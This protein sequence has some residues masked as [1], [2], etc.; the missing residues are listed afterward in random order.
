MEVFPHAISNAMENTAIRQNTISFFASSR[1][2]VSRPSIPENRPSSIFP[3]ALMSN[4]KIPNS[5]SG[6]FSVHGNEG[7]LDGTAADHIQTVCGGIVQGVLYS[8]LVCFN[9]NLYFYL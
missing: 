1:S 6:S 2:W 7:H 3:E 5:R 4:K 8:Y 9:N